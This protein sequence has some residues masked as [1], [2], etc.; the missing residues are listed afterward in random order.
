MNGGGPFNN[1]KERQEAERGNMR[2]CK[3]GLDGNGVPGSLSDEEDNSKECITNKTCESLRT[4]TDF[5]EK[6]QNCECQKKSN[7]SAVVHSNETRSTGNKISEKCTCESTTKKGNMECSRQARNTDSKYSSDLTS[8]RENCNCQK[9]DPTCQSSDEKESS[10]LKISNANNVQDLD[11]PCVK[12]KVADEYFK[13]SYDAKK[14]ECRPGSAGLINHGNLCY[15]NSVVQCL[16]SVRELRTYLLC[17]C[18]IFF[19]AFLICHLI[20][21]DVF[22]AYELFPIFS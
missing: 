1:R 5:N 22:P 15:I 12:D 9:T 8:A 11:E 10:S 19:S 18:W 7:N 6:N 4:K 17:K 21:L 13:L 20:Y 16:S 14:H 2:N 3:F